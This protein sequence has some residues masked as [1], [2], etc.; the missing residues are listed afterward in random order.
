MIRTT[1]LT[2]TLALGL[3]IAGHSELPIADPR[4]FSR[5]PGIR[6]WTNSGDVVRRSERVRVYYRTERDAFVTVLRVDTDGRVSVLFPRHPDDDSWA[7][8]GRSYSVSNWDR[9]TAFVVDDYA[10]VGYIFAIASEAPFEYRPIHDGQRWHFRDISDGRIHGD[11]RASLEELMV[12]MLPPDFYEFDTHITP[13]YV[14]RRYDYPRFVCY[15][16][17]SYVPFAT[18]NPY[19]SWCRS[20]TLV[21]WNDPWYYYPSYWYPTRYYGGRRVVYTYASARS[22]YVFKERTGRETGI[23]YRRRDLASSRRPE[24]AGIRAVNVGGVGRVPAPR[25]TP[26][27]RTVFE[28]GADDQT[29]VVGGG[30]R[31]APA[32]VNRT[33]TRG[34][35]VPQQQPSPEP[36][37]RPQAGESQPNSSPSQGAPDGRRRAGEPGIE[38]VPRAPEGREPRATE[39][40]TS[41]PT[42]RGGK[43]EPARGPEATRGEPRE[44]TRPERGTTPAQPSERT[45]PEATRPP[46]TSRPEPRA[47]PR[48]QPSQPRS[49]PRAQPSQPRS[50]GSSQPRSQ[51]SQPRSSGSSQ[52]SGGGGRRRP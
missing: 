14:E 41:E 37:R 16:C 42:T 13:Y 18:W 49:E 24:E 20:Y 31:T 17:H 30:R 43:S 19:H 26:D 9:G 29:P 48:A 6:V 8:A 38:I 51:P 7:E 32:D 3:P 22:R 45:R 34:R 46:G 12:A 4:S 10:G 1:M 25:S 27:G 40:R 2:L 28:R 47:E 39:P 15:D 23:D 21:V 44:Q 11:P 33:D 5:G 50:G 35:D 36:G 52:P